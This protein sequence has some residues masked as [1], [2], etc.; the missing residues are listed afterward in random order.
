MGDAQLVIPE[1]DKMTANKLC[2][3]PISVR[4]DGR[5]EPPMAYEFLE[6]THVVR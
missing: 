3:M 6:E 4:F 1:T 5:P 2:A